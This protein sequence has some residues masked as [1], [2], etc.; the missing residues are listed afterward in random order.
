M[1]FVFIKVYNMAASCL[2]PFMLDTRVLM[3]RYGCTYICIRVHFGSGM[4]AGMYVYY[5]YLCATRLG[6]IAFSVDFF[7][8]PSPHLQFFRKK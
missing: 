5:R 2:L 6:I 7:E 4:V 3:V 1:H 8:G